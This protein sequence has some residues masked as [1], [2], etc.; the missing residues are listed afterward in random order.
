MK[1]TRLVG[2]LFFALLSI[3]SVVHAQTDVNLAQG[4]EPYKPYMGGNLDSVSLTNGNLMLH[5]PLVSYPQRGGRLKLGFY[6]RYNGKGFTTLGP[7]GTGSWTFPMV[8]VDV[9]RDDLWEPRQQRT[10]FK[11]PGDNGTATVF[12]TTQSVITPDGSSHDLGWSSAAR[13][14]SAGPV[15]GSALGRRGV[16]DTLSTTQYTVDASCINS[17]IT[18]W[19][20]IVSQDPNGNQ[21]ITSTLGWTDTM[22]RLIQGQIQ[23]PVQFPRFAE[24][25]IY[26][27]GDGNTPGSTQ[28]VRMLPGGSTTDFTGCPANTV[29]ARLWLLPAFANSS[30]AS[31]TTAP[32]KFCYANFSVTSDF[33]VPGY[34]EFNSVLTMMQNVILPNGTMWSFSYNSHG[35]LSNITFP[36]GGS[37]SY[38]WANFKFCFV[39]VTDPTGNESVHVSSP[40]GGCNYY[41]TQ[42]K[43]FQGSQTSG[44]LLKQVDT[45]YNVYPNPSQEYTGGT[46]AGAAFPTT[47]TTT[48]NNGTVTKEETVYDTA[49]TYTALDLLCYNCADTPMATTQTRING[50]VASHNSFDYGHGAPGPLLRKTTESYVTLD[51]PSSIIT[52]DGSGN[53]CAQTDYAYDDPNRL[54][55]SGVTMMHGAPYPGAVRANLSSDIDI[56]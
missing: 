1:S 30:S 51:D 13:R 56:H 39:V 49:T 16:Q 44:T 11:V 52:Y 55:A 7:A 25:G 21:I 28:E 43:Y 24:P 10:S 5:I 41:E 27:G 19:N 9:Q 34:G 15:D 8:G 14:V 38:Q 42:A 37:I 18:Y 12:V 53:K 23:C 36:T 26:A 50:Q 40:I 20:P 31:S 32:M 47:V 33:G 29:S 46:S 3:C 4:L 17:P 45:V 6:L 35:D 54:V 2:A 48:W 22:G